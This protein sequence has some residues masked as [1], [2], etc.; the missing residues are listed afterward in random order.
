MPFAYPYAFFNTCGAYK[1][2]LGGR[3]GPK[4]VKEGTKTLKINK[5]VYDYA[6]HKIITV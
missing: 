1:R 4:D 6:T 2:G 3:R 5:N